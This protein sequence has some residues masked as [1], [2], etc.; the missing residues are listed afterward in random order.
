MKSSAAN[1]YAF[2]EKAKRYKTDVGLTP[3]IVRTFTARGEIGER[4]VRYSRHSAQK[5]ESFNV[6]P[7]NGIKRMRLKS[8]SDSHRQLQ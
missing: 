4:A 2:I 6:T 5:N 7:V 1:A 8:N 3:G